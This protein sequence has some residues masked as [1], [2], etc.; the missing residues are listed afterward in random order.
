MITKFEELE[1]RRMARE[2]TK[3]IY[4]VTNRPKFQ[5]DFNFRN[6]ICAA[7]L[8][9]GSNIAEG[10]ERG[11]R[12]EFVRFLMIAKAS[13]AEVR[14]QLYTALD[15]EYLD[16]QNFDLLMAYA[17]RVGQVIGGLRKSIISKGKS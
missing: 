14:S 12:K 4:L 9:V 11:S 7:S 6:Q 16:Q 3:Q 10:F 2:L 13:C 8:S 5:K 17:V 15:V 1:A